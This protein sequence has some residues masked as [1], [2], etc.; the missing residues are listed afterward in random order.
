MFSHFAFI[1][2]TLSARSPVQRLT[3]TIL[4]TLVLI[5]SGC[6][7]VPPSQENYSVDWQNQKA[8][9]EQL[10]TFKA[11][12]KIGY[13]DPEHRQSLNFI[14][15]QANSF[16][17]LKLLSVFGQTILTVQ[18]TPTGAMVT[19][20]DGKVQTAQQANALIQNLT[21]LAIPVSQLP[22]WIK[23]L[24]TQADNVTFNQ[25]NTVE[26]LNKMIDG[27]DWTLSYLNYQSVMNQQQSITLPKQ[28]LLHQSDTEIK[29]LISKWIL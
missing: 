24:P 23:G 14:L 6:S 12:G 27:R 8:V 25:S 28:M 15:K 20:S 3:T 9:L 19:N 10:D 4:A 16:S 7:S 18:M 26:S 22:D 29:I 11:T 13:K 5:L 21:G 1:R 17:E 2:T